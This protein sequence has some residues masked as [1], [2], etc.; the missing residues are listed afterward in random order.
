MVALLTFQ[1]I[2]IRPRNLVDVSRINMSTIIL[3]HRTSAPII[4]AP[5]SSH[6]LAHPE[7]EVAT[8]RGAAACNII[9]GLAFTSTCTLEEVASS[10]KAVRFIQTFVTYYSQ[11]VR[12]FKRDIT[13]SM[14][15]RAECNGFRAIILTADTPR[16]GRKEAD[17]RN[18]VIAPP[19][20]NFEGLLSTELASVSKTVTIQA[21]TKSIY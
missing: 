9:M 14:V 16:L 6:Q 4:V 2:S 7:G 13:A 8:A 19:F 18:K 3:G 15:Q 1:K 10:C 11:L 12:A 17:I 21:F 5:T 20:R